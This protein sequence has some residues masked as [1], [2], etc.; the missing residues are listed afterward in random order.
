MPGHRHPLEF[1]SGSADPAL[2]SYL[3]A[4]TGGAGLRTAIVVVCWHHDAANRRCVG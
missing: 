4:D 1:W 2:Y 3:A